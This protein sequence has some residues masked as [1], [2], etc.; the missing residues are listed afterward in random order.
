MKKQGPLLPR[1]IVYIVTILILLS[2]AFLSTP[3][4]SVQAS[5]AE[6][7]SQAQTTGIGS[8]LVSLS[9]DQASFVAEEPVIVHVRITNPNLEAIRVLK[10]LTP[11]HTMQDSLLAV[12]REGQPVHY[13]G[14]IYKRSA[15]TDEDYL[16]LQPGEALSG[17]I[18]LSALYDLSSSGN[19]AVTYDVGSPDL[20]GPETDGLSGAQ[21][22]LTSNTI[23]LFI[24]GRELPAKKDATPEVV[25]GSTSFTGCS[26]SRQS[27]LLTARENASLYAA[28]SQAYLHAGNPGARYITWFGAYTS[29][30]FNLARSHFDNIRGAMDTASVHFDCTCTNPG[31]YAY[32]YPNEPYN[33]Y[34]CG[35]F[36]S[37]PMTGSDSKAGT[38]IHE[39]SHFTVVAD[40]DDYVYGQTNA[41]NLAISNPDLAVRNADNHEYFA[42]NTP[43][44]AET[45][46]YETDN[47]AG[48]A[49]WILPGTP[50][51]HSIVPANDV[52]WVKFQLSTPSA[53]TLETSGPTASD[54]RM[55]L[56][57]SSLTEIAANDDKDEAAGNF[58]SRI[59]TCDSA[60]PLLPAGTYYVKVDEF[61]NNA[62]IP[63]YQLSLNL[64]CPS[65]FSDIPMDYW[66]KDYI[67]RL[68]SAGITGG[69]SVNPLAY[70]PETTVTRD[71]MAV[72]LLRGIH[73]PSYNPPGVG[74]S[75]GFA[76]VPTSY[77]AAAWIKQL[78]AE[79]IT[80]G[81]GGANYCPGAP[82]TRDQMAVFLL[83]AK[84]GKNYTPPAVGGTTGFTDVP[85][86]HW[87]AAWIKQLAAEGITGG[88]GTGIYCPG[89]PVNRAE[90]AVFLVRTFDLP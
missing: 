42:E 18:N 31:V 58:Y 30:R 15:P 29:S 19:Y 10:W 67:D 17:E 22:R 79:G 82:V 45:D 89:Q 36:W 34:L 62:Q 72:F 23:R 80:G 54:T 46:S 47:S 11:T 25:T 52:D 28:D 53:V 68:Y 14:A 69:C 56:Y 27:Q 55:W 90:M 85:T 50:Q 38:L 75:T 65:L 24:E 37:A 88:C 60:S 66:A 87:A 78:A 5:S 83:K 57:N 7:S 74:G 81:C 8:A 26:A 16:T 1:T 64:G 63:S 59:S 4:S 86:S 51:V 35:A 12:T 2:P 20:Y 49:N 76:D 77:W 73:G 3:V 44:I 6:P 84:Y 9:V 70:C 61:G 13:L 39:M 48:Q 43:P 40:T 71:Q 41:R 33:I 32:V 21:R